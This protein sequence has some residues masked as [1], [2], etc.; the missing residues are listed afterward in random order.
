MTKHKHLTSTSVDEELNDDDDVPTDGEL[1][2]T[3]ANGPKVSSATRMRHGVDSQVSHSLAEHAS[4][5]AKHDAKVREP[6]E[7]PC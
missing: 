5:P 1:R 2:A 6:K 7:P 3:G 4:H